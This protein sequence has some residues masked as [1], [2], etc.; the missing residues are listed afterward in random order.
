VA[1]ADAAHVQSTGG[2]FLRPLLRQTGRA[3]PERYSAPVQA[4]TFGGERQEK[5]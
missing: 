2:A 4:T 1:I 5:R 3:A